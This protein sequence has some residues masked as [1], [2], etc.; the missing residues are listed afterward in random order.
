MKKP[1]LLGL[2]T[3]AALSVLSASAALA[4]LAG[5]EAKCVSSMLKDGNKIAASRA[6]QIAACVSGA[7]AGTVPDLAACLAAADE[8][9]DAAVAKIEADVMKLCGYHPPEFGL[10][11]SFDDTVQ[12]SARVHTDGV[13]T[14]LLGTTPVVAAGADGACQAGALKAVQK[15]TAGYGKSFAKCVSSTIKGGATGS[16]GLLA[17]LSTDQAKAEAKLLAAVAKACEGA[18][19]ATALPGVCSAETASGVGECLKDRARC[20]ACRAAATSGALDADC[21]LVD[22]AAAN[23]SCSFPVSISGNVKDFYNGFWLENGVVWVLEHPELGTVTTDVDGYFAFSGLQEGE[24]VS[25]ILEHPNYHPIQNG[26]VRLGPTGAARVTFQAVTWSVYDGLAFV[27]GITPDEVNKCQM[28]TTVTRVGKSIYDPGAH[29]EKAATV[30]TSPALPDENG[31]IYFNSDV[32][33]QPSL[34]MTSDDGGVLYVQVT[35]GDYVWTAHKG[36]LIFTRIKSKCRAGL[37]VN[38]SP[39]WGLQLH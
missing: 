3:A 7:Q 17:C 19:P 12:E 24:E 22:D 38:A 8:K 26:T 11:A 31:P 20:R 37:L 10:P 28:V 15:F 2:T 36:D 1:L 32:L 29:G 13:L 39:P 34:T 21:D 30:T 14:D 23:D 4:Q 18:A 5:P 33:P 6:K 16:D 35:P 25:L 27:L 9:V